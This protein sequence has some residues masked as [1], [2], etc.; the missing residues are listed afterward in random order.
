MKRFQTF[1]NKMWPVEG[2]EFLP[3]GAMISLVYKSV[4][5]RGIDTD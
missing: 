1:Q 4:H 3:Y 5:A 2:F